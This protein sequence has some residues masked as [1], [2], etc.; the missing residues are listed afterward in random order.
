MFMS[1]KIALQIASKVDVLQIVTVKRRSKIVWR[2]FKLDMFSA[3]L[4][5]SLSSL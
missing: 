1:A 3:L 2:R 5:T 4:K